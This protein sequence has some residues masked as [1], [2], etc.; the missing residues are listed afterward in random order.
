MRDESKQLVELMMGDA[1]ARLKRQKLAAVQV[2]TAL[3]A[4]RQS[5]ADA[6][7]AI[8]EYMSVSGITRTQLI[9]DLA[10]SNGE[11]RTLGLV[12][13]SRTRAKRDQQTDTTDIHQDNDPDTTQQGNTAMSA[14]DDE[15]SVDGM[16]AN[17]Y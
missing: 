15:Q 13:P 9:N 10:L 11:A 5:Q 4:L 17:N 3:V 2:A 1:E 16:Y 6:C 12:S 8:N 14:H 7:T